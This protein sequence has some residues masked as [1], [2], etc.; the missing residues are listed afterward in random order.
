MPRHATITSIVIT[1]AGDAVHCPSYIQKSI[2]ISSAEAECV[3]EG[4]AAKDIKWLRTL[5]SE[6]ENTLD[7][8]PTSL[9]TTNLH[10]DYSG[11]I[12]MSNANAPTK[13]SK[14]IDIQHHFINEQVQNGQIRPVKVST[15]DQKADTFPK[16]LK[17]VKF[18]ANV[19]QIKCT[20]R[21]STKVR[22]FPHSD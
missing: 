8:N 2:S 4:N 14:H 12:A 21:V 9:H 11:A 19:D 20:A 16:A 18:D 6:W 13:R 7:T 17:R 15:M 10:I 5:A 1:L 3:T 22:S